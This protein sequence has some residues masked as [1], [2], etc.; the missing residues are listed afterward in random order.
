MDKE[1]EE[2]KQELIKMIENGD[3]SVEFMQEFIDGKEEM[4]ECK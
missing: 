3:L 4:E 1:K 2:V